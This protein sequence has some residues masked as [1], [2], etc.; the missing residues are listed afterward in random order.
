MHKLYNWNEYVVDLKEF[1]Q[2]IKL[3]L[4]WKFLKFEA[5]NCVNTIF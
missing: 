5:E 2:V 3:F 1:N 4:Q